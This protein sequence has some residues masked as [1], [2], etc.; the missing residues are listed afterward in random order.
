MA[1]SR[2][3]PRMPSGNTCGL[4]ALIYDPSFQINEEEE[5]ADPTDSSID[6]EEAD[7]TDT[8]LQIVRER[9]VIPEIPNPPAPEIE[10]GAQFFLMTKAS[11]HVELKDA[12]SGLEFDPTGEF[13]AS[14]NRVGC[15][16]IQ[17]FQTLRYYSDHIVRKTG[18]LLISSKSIELVVVQVADFGALK[19]QNARPTQLKMDCNVATSVAC[20]SMFPGEVLIY[21]LASFSSDP[22]TVLRLNRGTRITDVAFNGSDDSRLYGSGLNGIVNVWD[23]RT[24]YL[25]CLELVTH[26]LVH[27]ILSLK[28]IQLHQDS[29]KVFGGDH[30]GNV[31]MWDIRNPSIP[32]GVWRLRDLLVT[33]GY[34]QV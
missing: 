7:P 25:P 24:S 28:S 32:A 10:L 23:P 29:Q 3:N 19:V 13:L 12:T 5:E 27:D 17:R 18:G 16:T 30:S 20:T 8:S 2:F 6:E 11:P 14:V 21:D 9:K 34:V 4:L 15:L 1:E 33:I 26:E 31:F 22:L